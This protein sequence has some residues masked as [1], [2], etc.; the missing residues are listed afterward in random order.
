[1]THASLTLRERWP[2]LAVAF[3]LI[4]VTVGWRF[5]RWPGSMTHDGLW[6]LQG[7]ET[8]QAT[9]YHPYL[10]TILAAIFAVPFQSIGLYTTLQSIY[11]VATIL[12]IVDHSYRHERVALLA[13][14]IGALFVLSIPVGL[15]MGMFWKD[16]PFAFGV[17]FIAYSI[18]G[19]SRRQD[20][21]HGG[22]FWLL[23]CAST[24]FVTFM[25]HGHLFNLAVVP[26]LLYA[27]TRNRRVALFSFLTAGVVW[28][29]MLV[30]ALTWLPVRND[31]NHMARVGVLV[32]TQPFLATLSAPGGYVTDDPAADQ[33]LLQSLFVPNALQLYNPKYGDAG[34]IRPGEELPP[35][36]R[37]R[38]VKRVAKLCLLNVSKC[39]GDRVQLFAATLFPAD[40]VYGMTFYDLGQTPGPCAS[41]YGMRPDHC[42]ILKRYVSDEKPRA[43]ASRAQF[44]VD[45]VEQREHWGLR[46]VYWNNALGVA[47]LFV[48]LVFWSPRARIWWAALFVA[49]QCAVPFAFAT[50]NDFR[51]Y[52]PL[53]L[54]GLLF[55]PILGRQVF[56]TVMRFARRQV[57]STVVTQS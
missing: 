3:A 57:S 53:Y 24:T 12:W 52:F 16:V 37:R 33:Q 6:I 28:L 23:L 40:R 11:G 2:V 5:M 1:M 38:L 18:Y 29:A 46:L 17:M 22:G 41:I 14:A 27:T 10:N 44:V 39:V 8:R 30:S 15:Y 48:A 19:I 7:A 32:A 25:R 45:R 56:A 43:L 21:L 55:T 54:W 42:G 13:L 50:A 26:L 51:Y 4:V 20:E 35:D 9:T 36:A 49:I 31:P 47:M 34:L